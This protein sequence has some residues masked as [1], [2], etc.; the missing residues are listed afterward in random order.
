MVAVEVAAVALASA[1]A[2]VVAAAV[3]VVLIQDYRVGR[4]ALH[5][6]IVCVKRKRSAVRSYMPRFVKLSVRACGL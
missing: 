6:E 3:A 5:A 4:I 1:A 2:S